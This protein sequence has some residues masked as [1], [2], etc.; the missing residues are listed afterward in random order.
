[1]KM[2]DLTHPLETPARQPRNGQGCLYRKKTSAIQVSLNYSHLY[3]KVYLDLN[4][5][6][7]LKDNGNCFVIS[8]TSDITS[9]CSLSASAGAEAEYINLQNQNDKLVLLLSS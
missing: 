2:F 4:G 6:R 1:M 9:V 7:I 5:L 3:C 8:E